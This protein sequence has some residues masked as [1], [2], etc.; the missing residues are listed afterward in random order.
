MIAPN[1]CHSL[2]THSSDTALLSSLRLNPEDEDILKTVREEV[3][4]IIKDG[5]NEHRAHMKR[6][7]LVYELPTPHFRT[8]GSYIYRTIINP[9][10]PPRQQVDLDLGI[11]LPFDNLVG[12]VAPSESAKTYFD[13]IN[14]ILV[15][16]GQWTSEIKDKCIR[17]FV[18][19]R[20]HVD[21]PLYGVPAED[22][23]KVKDAVASRKV[24][25]VKSDLP[26]D[27]LFPPEPQ[28]TCIHL[29]LSSGNWI[30]SDP[31]MIINW[32]SALCSQYGANNA[33]RSVCK[34]LKAWRDERW[35]NGGGPS[36]IFLLACVL[37]NYRH[38]DGHH[39]N[40]LFEVINA[41]PECLDSPVLV[42]A[43]SPGGGEDQE[44]L[45]DRINQDKREEFNSAFV[46]L[47]KQYSIAMTTQDRESANNILCSLFGFRLPFDPDRIVRTEPPSPRQQ[48]LST[49]A[50]IAP[51]YISK[52]SSG[53]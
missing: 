2:F 53:G 35:K 23:R 25:I 47:Q 32:V 31:L 16:D 48:V 33:I 7:S 46:E 49:P 38:T 5:F 29:A 30:P 6:D 10:Y 21:L 52:E 27:A 8:Q 24:A 44:D 11:Y 26:C 37:H 40:L 41:L 28:L 4:Q 51:M 19:K 13:V 9:A 18:N 42:P 22:F 45:R 1:N 3:K 36:S 43:P 14:D 20:I 17:I 39:H 50:K 34:Y 12:D 15:R